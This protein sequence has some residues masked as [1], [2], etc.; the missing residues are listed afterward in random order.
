MQVRTSIL[1]SNIVVLILKYY[2]RITYYS[3]KDDKFS[4]EIIIGNYP[5]YSSK[6][7]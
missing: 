1:L 7:D 4:N 6:E 2:Y 3:M 5:Q